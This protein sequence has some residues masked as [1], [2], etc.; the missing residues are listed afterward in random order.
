MLDSNA[1]TSGGSLCCDGLDQ[2]PWKVFIKRSPETAWVP[3]AALRTRSEALQHV[4]TL[5]R[6]VATA[7][8]AIA[9]ETGSRAQP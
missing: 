4:G 8:F 2:A 6:L 5:K 1:P 9:F 3:I 7:V